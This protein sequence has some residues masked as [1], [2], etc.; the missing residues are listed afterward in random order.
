MVIRKA[1]RMKTKKRRQVMLAQETGYKRKL[2]SIKKLN[3]KLI[4]IQS[5]MILLDNTR[6]KLLK[7]IQ[8]LVS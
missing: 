3:Q 4:K 2:V 7:N 6:A 5:E 1:K 8:K